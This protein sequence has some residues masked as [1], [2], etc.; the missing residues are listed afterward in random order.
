MK[1]A[2]PALRPTGM[3]LEAW[4][5]AMHRLGYPDATVAAVAAAETP[6][7]SGV[8]YTTDAVRAAEESH[9]TAMGPP[10]RT[11]GN[12]TAVWLDAPT[13]Q[14][15]M[16]QAQVHNGGNLSQELRDILHRTMA[17]QRIANEKATPEG[18]SGMAG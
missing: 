14:W 13:R 7:T 16:A 4:V 3:S 11:N 1:S 17:M 18:K 15:L 6:T 2:K 5:Q 8:T 10:N 9:G 12:Y